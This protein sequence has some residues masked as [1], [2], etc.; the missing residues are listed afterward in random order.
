VKWV[1][2]LALLR[3][4]ANNFFYI[5]NLKLTKAR[6]MA[7]R[8]RADARRHVESQQLDCSC[9]SRSRG[10]AAVTGN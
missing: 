10:K 2:D 6:V 7:T 8:P 9:M 3:N 5:C 1:A 4:E